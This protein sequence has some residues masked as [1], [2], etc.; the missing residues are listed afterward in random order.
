MDGQEKIDNLFPDVSPYFI[1][2]HEITM[3]D[4]VFFKKKKKSFVLNHFKNMLDKVHESHLGIAKCKQLAGDTMFWPGMASQIEDKI[5]RCAVCQSF[6]NSPQTEPLK[7][8]E[9]PNVLYHKVGVDFFHCQQATYLLIVVYYSKF[10][11]IVEVETAT[12]KDTIEVL[13]QM[14]GRHR[15][16]HI[17][18][19][20]KGP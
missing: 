7:P 12:T 6:H 1:L 3:C 5:A 9:I 16:P 2:R 11:E 19:S 17:V 10:L 15:I 18:V 20:D 4:G 14:I 8:H 13:K